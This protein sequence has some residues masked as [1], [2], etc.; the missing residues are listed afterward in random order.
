MFREGW[1]ILRI[2]SWARAWVWGRKVVQCAVRL[3]VFWASWQ[4]TTFP[5]VTAAETWGQHASQRPAPQSPRWGRGREAGKAP[6][7]GFLL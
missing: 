7:S 2:G 3:D 6:A 4:G 5:C 1:R